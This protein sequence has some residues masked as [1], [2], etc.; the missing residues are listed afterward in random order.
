VRLRS[1]LRR[2]YL[3]PEFLLGPLKDFLRE[4][5][6]LLGAI[7]VETDQ[8]MWS[9]ASKRLDELLE[10]LKR[11]SEFYLEMKNIE[12]EEQRRELAALERAREA[13]AAIVKIL[14]RKTQAW[15]KW[16]RRRRA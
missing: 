5:E 14:P 15:V 7:G 3:R 11:P 8:T 10:V 2:R 12:D 9:E 16:P 4:L 6:Q 1:V 13:A